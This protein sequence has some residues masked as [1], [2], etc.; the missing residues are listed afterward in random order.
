MFVN[1]I[2]NLICYLFF[3][4]PNPSIAYTHV[5]VRGKEI[6]KSNHYEIHYIVAHENIFRY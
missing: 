3:P 1:F 6:R 5:L 2:R 4:L